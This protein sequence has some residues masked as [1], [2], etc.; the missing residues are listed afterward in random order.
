MRRSRKARQVLL[1]T[2]NLLS[3]SDGE[4]VVAPTLDMVL[5]CYYMTVDGTPQP[6][7]QV[8]AFGSADK[9]HAAYDLG[10]LHIHAPIRLRSNGSIIE[11]TVGRVLFNAIVP[12]SLGFRNEVMDKKAL[13]SL[14]SSVYQELGSERTVEFV[15]A[16]KDI[17]FRYATQSGISIAASDISVP[18]AKTGLMA[19]ADQ[20]IDTLEEQFQMGLMTENERY[21]AAID[22]WQEATDQIQGALE[23]SLD[24]L[25]PLALMADS[26]AKGNIAQIRQMGGM[27]GL[28]SDP[29]GRIIDLP[30]RSSFRE[31]LSVLEY[32][33]S[34]HGARKGLAD[35][36]LRTADSGY[37]TRRMIDVAQDVIVLDEDCTE[38]GDAIGGLWLRERAE[39]GLLASL[40]ER[41]TGRWTAS[42][43]AHPETGEL[44]AEANS[45]IDE[46]LARLIVEAQVEQV[47]VRSPLTCMA[48]RGVCRR[49]YGA[50]SP[51]ANSSRSASP[52]ASS[53]RSRSV[54]RARS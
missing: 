52:S 22:V 17:G 31:G 3:P 54:S 43:V 10:Q 42:P 34:T 53:P 14:V 21:L 39:R 23:D 19:S 46:D 27:R 12:D 40:D 18:Q 32:F 38:D 29:S 36:A 15:D 4:P 6:D 41:L 49:C 35:T 16:I 7:A 45:E 5:G 51:P 11:T 2:R 30:I 24:R 50:R 13:R 26:G 44:I 8:R 20:R 9:V 33:T 48:R 28:M 25:G 47:H 1:S 37:L